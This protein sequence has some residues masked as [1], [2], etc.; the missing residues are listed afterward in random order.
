[1]DIRTWLDGLGLGQF[2]D[3]FEENGVDSDLLPELDNDDL[4]DMGVARVADRKTILRSIRS[5]SAEPAPAETVEHPARQRPARPEAERRQL[6]VMFSDLVDSTAL[7][8]RLDPEELRDVMRRYQDAVSGAVT[9]FGGHI[10]QYL[11]DGVLVHFGWPHAYEDQA[12]RAVRAGL[13]AVAAITELDGQSSQPIQARIGI[14]SGQVV[15]GDLVGE[16]SLNEGAVSGDTPNLAARLQGVAAPNEV[17][18]DEATRQLAGNAFVLDDLGPRTLKGFDDPVGAWRV[19]GERTFESRFQASRGQT[20]TRLVGREHELGLMCDRWEMATSGEGQVVL[21]TGEAGIGKS[22][23]TQALV[24]QVEETE[25]FRLRLQCSPYHANSA[26]F[27]L[28]VH[29]ERA[30]RLQP[31]DSVPQKL[32]KLEALFR[33]A[34]EADD[35]GI[36]LIANLLSIPFEERFGTLDLTPQQI[37]Q[38]TLDVL[39]A[40]FFGLAAQKPVLFI[41]EDAHWIDP[42]SHELLE[43]L[44]LRAERASIFFVITH[45]PEWQAPFSNLTYVTSLQLNRLGRRQIAEIVK[46]VAENSIPEALVDQVLE[47]SDGI[48]LFVEEMARSLVE[49]G[50][51]A[52]MSVNDIPESL[53]A[54]LM[55]RLDHLPVAAKELAQFASVIGREIDL[56]LLTRVLGRSRS[57]VSEPVEV[58]VKAQLI[59]RAGVSGDGSIV[60][61][62][63]LIRDAAYQ[64]LL[65][66]RRRDTHARIADTIER[67]FP[68]IVET[69]PELLARHHTEAHNVEQAVSYWRRAGE[70]AARRLADKEAV[71]HFRN[72]LE[73]LTLKEAG[74]D[75]D[76]EELEILLALGVPLIAATGYASDEV[77]KAFLRAEALCLGL[78]D[79]DNLFPVRRG[80]WNFYLDRPDFERGLTVAE[81]LLDS[82]QQSGNAEEVALAHRAVGSVNFYTGNLLAAHEAFEASLRGFE[83]D[84]RDTNLSRYGESG[85]L[86]SQQYL[87]WTQLFCG[88]PVQGRA[89]SQTAFDMACD[90]NHP[91]SQAFARAMLMLAL[92][93]CRDAAACQRHAIENIRL[94]ED[95]G[96][97]FWLSMSLMMKG[98]ADGVLGELPGGLADWRRGID[99]WR[100]TGAAIHVPHYLCIPAELYGQYGKTEEGLQ[101][102]DQSLAE[103]ARTGDRYWLAEIHR[104]AGLLYG[105]AGK[106]DEAV[107][108]FGEAVGVSRQQG[109]RFLELRAARDHARLLASSGA[110]R[111]AVE[112]L[113]PV[114][115]AFAEGYDLPDLVEAKALLDELGY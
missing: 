39:A 103:T 83:G 4:K 37:K 99:M 46:A 113:G 42:T 3:A 80:L 81:A 97:V 24:E 12:E 52:A 93:A 88:F 58:L 61:R 71:D 55:A 64:S 34:G 10:A 1:M 59:F 47:R 82:A 23:L 17:V 13:A 106:R 68:D 108:Y 112:L 70:R 53:Q 60:F 107:A 65:L 8:N 28:I 100:G 109:A 38:R 92:K 14:A 72:A 30:A 18:V 41:F 75:R 6:T 104:N 5:L 22:R 115:D 69:Q 63:N 95:H 45:R 20:L 29:L 57:A 48:P 98:W 74:Q 87:A 101:A 43:G 7:S 79:R 40:Q 9:R 102:I 25:H 78:D 67:D 21:L 44:V 50:V 110:Q 91:L 94:C 96:L 85:S 105:A 73:Q 89:S 114:Y 66:S 35:T 32:E 31:S 16:G 11:G 27:P 26:L 90:L 51:S 56:D 62:H 2:A 33:E 84:L 19:V 49:R 111:D 77:E 54:S 36:A 15:I 86:V 76:R